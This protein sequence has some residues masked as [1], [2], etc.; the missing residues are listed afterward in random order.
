MYL[1]YVNACEFDDARQYLA[2]EHH[3]QL[4]NPYSSYEACRSQ[5]VIYPGKI[6]Q[7]G[8]V[9][10]DTDRFECDYLVF[11]DNGSN[12]LRTVFLLEND[13]IIRVYPGTFS[14][15]YP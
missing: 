9:E 13:K 8:C 7:V 2:P 12:T 15:P 4:V 5:N 11:D 3:Q 14:R 10:I 1:R 6:I